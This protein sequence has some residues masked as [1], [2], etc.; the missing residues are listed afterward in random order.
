MHS[1]C[2]WDELLRHQ[3][4]FLKTCRHTLTIV[5]CSFF[6]KNST[7]QENKLLS[8]VGEIQYNQGS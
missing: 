2:L 4:D 5:K 1:S 7:S 6:V 3:E 8:N